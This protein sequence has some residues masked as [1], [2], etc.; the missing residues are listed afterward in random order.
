[1][2]IL[3]GPTGVG[4]S[5]LAILLAQNLPTEIIN[6]DVG[7][8]YAPLTIGTA[9]PAWR[10]ST[11]PHYMFDILNTPINYTIVQYRTA[12]LQL[13]SEI[14]SR[15]KIPLVVGGSGF[16]LK[17]LLFPPV[18]ESLNVA[19]QTIYDTATVPLWEQLYAID[20]ERATTIQSHDTYRITRA[21]DIWYSTGIKPSAYKPRYSDTL[22]SYHLVWVTR[23]RQDLYNRINARVCAMF[24][25]G[26]LDEVRALDHEWISFILQKKIIGYNEIVAFM[27]G[28][29]AG[30]GEHQ[31]LV[32]AIQQR[33]RHYARRQTIFWRM[34]ER[35]LNLAWLTLPTSAMA[36]T[37]INLT[38]RDQ[39]VYIKQLLH[40]C[41]LLD[42]KG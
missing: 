42:Q 3:Y 28:L 4:K 15:N 9:K 36:I 12:F 20:S 5:E 21:L 39:D 31:R 38:S 18:H 7:Q 1:M 25:Q 32:S 37:T 10:S 30:S 16:Y 27:H 26:W 17:S 24:A 8:F 29:D 41:R 22:G 33:T 14:R 11:T 2:I 23:D 6:M 35:E 34:L 40:S 13:I 19:K